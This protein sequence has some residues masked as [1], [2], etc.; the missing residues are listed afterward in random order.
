MI[1]MTWKL[2]VILVLNALNS[3]Q[4]IIIYYVRSYLFLFEK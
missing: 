1:Q 3:L 2:I 4:V